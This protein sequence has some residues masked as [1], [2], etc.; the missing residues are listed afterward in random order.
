MKRALLALVLC[1]CARVPGTTTPRERLP[2]PVVTLVSVSPA[3]S[4]G[5]DLVTI[6]FKTTRAGTAYLTLDDAAGARVLAREAIEE[7]GST[8]ITVSSTFPGSELLAGPNSVRVA[9]IAAD[10][11][12]GF[13]TAPVTRAGGDP[14]AVGGTVSGL[15]GTGMTLALDAP[16][17]AN[18]QTVPIL[19]NGAFT[20]PATVPDGTVVTAVTV[21][22]APT[23]PSQNCTVTLAG[24]GAASGFTVGASDFSDLRVACVTPAGPAMRSIGGTVSGLYGTGLTLSLTSPAGNQSKPLTSDGVFTFGATILEGSTVASITISAQPTSPT[25]TCTVDL[26]AGVP[27][28]AF[29]IPAGS[30]FSAIRVLCGA[31]HPNEVPVVFF[32]DITSGPNSGGVGGNGAFITIYGERFGTTLPK[33]TIGGVEVAVYGTYGSAGYGQNYAGGARG[34]DRMYV[35]PGAAVPSGAQPL[36]VWRDTRSPS[37]AVTFTIRSGTITELTTGSNLDTTFAAAAAGSIY[38]LHGGTYDTAS[39]NC[40]ASAA[41]KATLCFKGSPAG[42]PANPVAVLGYPGETATIDVAAA[43]QQTVTIRT[44]NATP[45]TLANLTFN[46]SGGSARLITVFAET[47]VRLIG[48]SFGTQASSAS[49][50]APHVRLSKTLGRTAILGN[51]FALNSDTDNILYSNPSATKPLVDE[52]DIGY[53]EFAGAAPDGG[54]AYSF[55]GN[56]TLRVEQDVTLMTVHHNRFQGGYRGVF[57]QDGYDGGATRIVS[58]VIGELHVFNNVFLDGLGA[59]GAEQIYLEVARGATYVTHNSMYTPDDIILKVIDNPA[60][61]AQ[62]WFKRNLISEGFSFSAPHY[63]DEILEDGLLAFRPAPG[64]FTF[65]YNLWVPSVVGGPASVSGAND[66]LVGTTAGVMM[67]NFGTG[68]L[69]LQAASPAID[70]GTTEA[71]G[72]VSVTN[73]YLGF[74]RAWDGDGNGSSVPDIGA[75]EYVP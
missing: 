52:I 72:S 68:D 19:A 54:T 47:P 55:G 25:Q 13:V 26:G 35:Q 59:S 49:V 57:V 17:S 28:T 14:R 21:G 8:D 1:A 69:S 16:G 30:D 70:K 48:N 15:E 37:N 67:T 5:T 58:G 40:D 74:P 53:N 44:G 2:A 73:D 32:T 42:G 18:D 45:V 29:T 3:I 60:D 64:G 27:A 75:F 66:V 31:R 43:A 41:D 4:T 65:N 7:T 71:T 61:T 34:L 38:Y 51:T 6:V 10:G 23:G 9:V 46:N 24:G 12:R 11:T 33:V 50:D 20:F 22:A 36:I 39:A 62:V 56:I 63:I